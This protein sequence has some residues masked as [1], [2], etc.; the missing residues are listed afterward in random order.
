MSEQQSSEKTEPIGRFG[1]AF[2]AAIE[3]DWAITE[4]AYRSALAVAGRLNFDRAVEGI[5]APRLE[6]TRTVGIRDGVAIIPIEGIIFRYADFFTYYCGGCTI[7][8]LAKD[9]NAALTDT[10]VHAIMF[11]INS[12]GGEVTGVSEMADM[13]YNARSRKPMT[14]RVGGTMAS[15][16]LWL[17]TAAGE[18]RIDDTARIGS[19]GVMAAYLDDRKSMEM[20]GLEEIEFISSQS[21]YKNAKPWTD[22]GRKRIQARLDALC[23]IFGEKVALHRDVDVETVWKNFGQGDTFVGQAAIDAGLA[24]RM[25]SFEETLY[26][27]ARTHN[28]YFVDTTAREKTIKD[29]AA[30]SFQPVIESGTSEEAPIIENG[31]LMSEKTIDLATEAADETSVHTEQPKASAETNSSAVAPNDDMAAIRAELERERA[32]AAN[33]TARIAKLEAE[34]TENWIVEQV[35]DLHG[36][37]EAQTKVLGALVKAYGKDSDEVASYL[38]LQQAQAAQIETGDLF[39][40][41]GKGGSDT[42]N[43]AEAQ[44]TQLARERA[45]AEGVSFEKAYTAVLAENKELAKEVV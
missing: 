34:A 28:P 26:D 25:G 2:M 4:D 9:F 23:E 10:K 19:I 7:D 43:S 31:E 14:A 11:E 29:P 41:K 17:G 1:R 16:A 21:P 42:D 5:D 27:L 15:A 20:I 24:D 22:E 44:L 32:N 6:Y 33:A 30:V 18:V 38:T 13:I 37:T 35:K 12:P 3:S 8:Q 45:T 36:E 39:S 40:A